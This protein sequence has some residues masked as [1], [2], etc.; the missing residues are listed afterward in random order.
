MTEDRLAAWQRAADRMAD[1]PDVAARQ[2]GGALDEAIDATRALA[3]ER[4]AARSDAARLRA[5]LERL[6]GAVEA[7]DLSTPR[8]TAEDVTRLMLLAYAMETARAAT[9]GEGAASTVPPASPC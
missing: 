4:D 3:A 6:I 2:A 8:P 1:H 7:Q 9:A 5:A